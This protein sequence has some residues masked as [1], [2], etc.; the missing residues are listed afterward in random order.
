MRMRVSFVTMS[1]LKLLTEREVIL[2]LQ[3]SL[4]RESESFYL[5]LNF[6]NDDSGLAVNIFIP[7]AD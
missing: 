6:E 5:L 7:L 2:A 1:T 3:M 4:Q